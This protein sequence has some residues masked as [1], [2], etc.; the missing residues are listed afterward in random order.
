VSEVGQSSEKTSA[1]DLGED[2]EARNG[3]EVLGSVSNVAADKKAN[4]NC[5]RSQLS[6]AICGWRC[7]RGGPWLDRSCLRGA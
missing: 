7:R 6:R 4:A 5:H 1:R 2:V 3:T